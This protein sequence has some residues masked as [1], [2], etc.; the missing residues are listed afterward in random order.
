MKY[1]LSSYLHE[2]KDSLLKWN[3]NMQ[4]RAVIV[5]TNNPIIEMM[6]L[7]WNIWLEYENMLQNS[8]SRLFFTLIIIAALKLN[9]LVVI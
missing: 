3:F 1:I 6:K 5:V 2:L 7:F 8:E 9:I 4:V